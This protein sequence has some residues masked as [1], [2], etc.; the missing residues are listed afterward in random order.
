[1]TRTTVTIPG[2]LELFLEGAVE[3]G[4]FSSKSQVVETAVD[5]AYEDVNMR[6]LAALS[7]FQ[8]EK[9]E[10]QEALELADAE[11]QQIRA[12]LADKLEIEP[13]EEIPNQDILDTIYEGFSTTIEDDG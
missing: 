2:E 8:S 11:D 13:Q 4:A 10:P 6:A 5:A 12:I 7:L 3:T 1:M 9:L